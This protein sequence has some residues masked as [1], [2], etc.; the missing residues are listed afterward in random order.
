MLELN[1][2]NEGQND[3]KYKISKYPDGQQDLT[4]TKLGVITPVRGVDEVVIKSRLKNFKD[5][6]LIICA[7]QALI[8]MGVKTIKLYVPY[9]IG[10]RSDR[11]F[12]YG[13]VN[14]IKHVIAPIINSQNF[15]SVTVVDPHSDVLEACINNFNKINNFNLVKFALTDIDNK[16]GTQDRICLVSPDAG[17]YKK[18]FDVAAHFNIDNLITATKVRDIKTGKIIHTEVP[19]IDESK[20]LNYV[21]VDDICDG[22]RTFIE[23]A[24]AIK[25]KDENAKIYLIVTHGIFSNSFYELSKLFEKVY[26]TNSYSDIDVES[27]S[28]Y[29]VPNGFLKQLNVY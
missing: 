1:L 2:I 25:E 23:I 17:A 22:G 28:D 24:K 18:I 29:T 11:K 27:H 10:A 16:N 14:Y 4:I 12:V 3:I 7:N 8:E 5:L 15:D 13:G 19:N 6:E 20:N 9:F 26:S 21:I